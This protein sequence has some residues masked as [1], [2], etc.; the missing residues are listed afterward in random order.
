MAISEEDFL[1]KPQQ[2]SRRLSP[3]Q[4]R[5]LEA[6]FSA[7]QKLHADRKLQLATRLGVSPRQVAVWY[8]NRRARH[9]TQTIEFDYRS[10]Q[11]RLEDALADKRRLEKEVET[12]RTELDRAR[13]MLLLASAASPN[14][15]GC[16]SHDH[17]RPH[18]LDD[19]DRVS[20]SSLDND[21][22]ADQ[23]IV[24]E[25]PVDEFYACLSPWS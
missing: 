7:N 9:K 17:L 22:Y 2:R 20:S 6:S 1:I 19:R 5:L 24:D 10:I 18:V 16:N 12:L 3:A 8:Q 14:I 4:V 21:K 25:L 13:E 23:E 11:L 15:S